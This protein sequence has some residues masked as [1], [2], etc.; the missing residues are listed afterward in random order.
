[1]GVTWV[2]EA[3]QTAKSVERLLESAGAEL[4]GT[5]LVDITPFNP[6]VITGDYV[7]NI[8]IHHSKYPQST[9]SIC[10]VDSSFK[11]SPKAV[12]DRGFD[13][14]LAK[15]SNGLI[16]DTPGK[17]EINGNEFKL[18]DWFVR[19]GTAVQGTTMKGVTVEIEYDA[20]IVVVQC[21]EMLIEFVTAL[22]DKYVD[23]QPEIFNSTE[24]PE[25]YLP[26]DTM[27][28]YLLIAAK[29]RKKT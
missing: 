25:T 21:K 2:F 20:S 7:T 9:F 15:L 29:M 8:V 4:I 18:A 5:F 14:I 10:P 16:I 27:W 3:E 11:K 1:M 23:T 12:C 13:L 28:Q 6:P 26:L 24:K 17:I 22:F 19:V